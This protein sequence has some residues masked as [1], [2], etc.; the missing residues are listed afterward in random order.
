MF[1]F[2]SVKSIVAK[3]VAVVDGSA[4]SS[5]EGISISINE[6]NEEL[7]VRGS[8][9]LSFDSTILVRY[10]G[11]DHSISIP[12][13]VEVLGSSCFEYA[14]FQESISFESE[15][16]LKR[17]G[18]K[19]FSYSGIKL[20]VIPRSVEIL[21]LSCFE[22]CE[23]LSSVLFESDSALKR[24]ESNAFRFTALNAIIIPKTVE[25]IGSRCFA[26]CESLSSISFESESVLQR[27]ETEAFLRTNFTSV[28]VPSTIQMVAAFAFPDLCNVSGLPSQTVQ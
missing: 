3:I 26:Y 24:I 15:S 21:C 7:I 16:R 2:S 27:I 14:K 11:G 23:S 9:F 10:F 20:I 6:E 22:C 17:V 13:D 19:A 12:N 4:F 25:V 8:F 28:T 1:S 18:P 5:G